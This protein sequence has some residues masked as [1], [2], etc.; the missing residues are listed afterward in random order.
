MIGCVGGAALPDVVVVNTAPLRLA[1]SRMIAP[2][3]SP[4]H[5]GPVFLALSPGLRD[6]VRR[7]GAQPGT[8]VHYYEPQGR[9]GSVA[10]H[11]GY[12]IGEQPV[13]ATDLIA[14]VELPVVRVASTIHRGGTAGI[15]KAYDSL[16]AW[17]EQSGYR[18][19][20][21]SRE[22]YCEMGPEGP[23]ITEIQIPIAEGS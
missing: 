7:S 9:D 13:P 2:G 3:L 23:R 15:V 21:Y 20:G 14:I 1:E 17:I 5:I 16:L 19:A 11:I 10:V 8:L 12:E 22:L 6:H 4:E 18:R